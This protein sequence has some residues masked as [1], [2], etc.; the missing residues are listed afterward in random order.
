MTDLSPCLK[1]DTEVIS[2][3]LSGELLV[4]LNAA[5]P[6]IQQML[7]E[8]WTAAEMEH[9]WFILIQQLLTKVKSEPP[10]KWNKNRTEFAENK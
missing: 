3:E 2:G 6:L 7:G 5:C 10:P 4:P 1:D 8:E 9:A